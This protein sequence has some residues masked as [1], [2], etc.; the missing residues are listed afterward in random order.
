MF[1][2]LAQQ[3][4]PG[5]FS[6]FHRVAGL[7]GNVEEASAVQRLRVAFDCDV[8]AA[9]EQIAECLSR[10]N[11]R[12][13]CR[14]L[15]RWNVDQILDELRAQ[16]GCGEDSNVAVRPGGKFGCRKTFERQQRI[17]WPHA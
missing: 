11:L 17:A 8:T 9:A 15:A 10:M 6:H 14:A 16:H 1:V 4:E 2:T 7:F 13:C 3:K 12:R 5:G